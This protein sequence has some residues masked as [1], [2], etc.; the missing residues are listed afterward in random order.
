MYDRN[1]L[2]KIIDDESKSIKI[3]TKVFCFVLKLFLSYPS[4]SSSACSSAPNT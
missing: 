2:Q 3:A 1:I 4:V